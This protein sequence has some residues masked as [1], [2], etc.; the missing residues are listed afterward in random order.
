MATAGTRRLQRSAGRVETQAAEGGDAAPSPSKRAPRTRLPTSRA[1]LPIIILSQSRNPQC[2]RLRRPE[3]WLISTKADLF[4]SLISDRIGRFVLEV[5]LAAL[6]GREVGARM[7]A[8]SL[9]DAD[10]RTPNHRAHAH[11]RSLRAPARSSRRR[12]WCATAAHAP[13]TIA[14]SGALPSSPAWLRDVRGCPKLERL[15]QLGGC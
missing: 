15:R 7:D 9:Q 13:D 4:A 1:S 3:V 2:G 6:D 12:S 10:A 5:D 11:A 14:D 8:D